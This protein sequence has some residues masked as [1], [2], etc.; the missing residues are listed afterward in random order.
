VAVAVNDDVFG[1]EVA[2]E[3]LPGVEVGD[4]G[5][6]FEEVEFGLCLLH[7]SYSPQQ[8]EQFSAMAV[9]HAE[10]QVMLRFE[11]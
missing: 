6:G 9:L 11:T 3:D 10:Y 1:F 8:I 7:T 5:E 2:V 4:G